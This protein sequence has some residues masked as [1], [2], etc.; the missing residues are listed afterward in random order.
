MN[1]NNDSVFKDLTSLDAGNANLYRKIYAAERD[2]FELVK[3]NTVAAGRIA[4]KRGVRWFGVGFAV[5]PNTSLKDIVDIRETF[6]E[7]VEESDFGVNLASFRPRVIHHSKNK[8]VVPQRHNGMYHE[9]AK[10][11]RE[12]IEYP[13]LERYGDKVRIDHKFG[14]F[15]DCDRDEVAK[16]GWGGSWLATLDH[17]AQ[18]SIVSHLTG[19]SNNPS[20]WGSALEGGGFGYAWNSKQRREAQRRVIEGQ[21]KLPMANGFRSVDA[22]IEK[23]KRR[24]PE[25]LCEEAVD[26]LMEVIESWD[27][28]RS[29]RPEFVG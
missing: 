1:S 10:T 2:V 8:V 4:A 6:C 13:L 11:I 19:A 7:L 29:K 9:L 14:N 27:F 17:L 20:A 22:F 12:E 25:P 24:F 21:I 15:S 5:M 26:E 16:G 3:A 28:Y 18:G 23:V